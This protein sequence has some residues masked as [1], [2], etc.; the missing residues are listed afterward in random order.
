MVKHMP[1]TFSTSKVLAVIAS[2]VAII[3]QVSPALAKALT[4]AGLPVWAH[5]IMVV[6]GVLGVLKVTWSPS[7]SEKVQVAAVAQLDNAVPKVA[8]EVLRQS[9]PPGKP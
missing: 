5:Y 4:D 9:V 3:C 8:A 6:A 1:S 2:A 7:V